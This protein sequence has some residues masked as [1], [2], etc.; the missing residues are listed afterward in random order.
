MRCHLHPNQVCPPGVTGKA[1]P[2]MGRVQSDSSDLRVAWASSATKGFGEPTS[3][4]NP[5]GD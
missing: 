5:T 1:Q 4:T 2:S 3:P